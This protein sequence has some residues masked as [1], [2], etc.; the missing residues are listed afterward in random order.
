MARHLYWAYAV[1][2]VGTP[3]SC[4][5]EQPSMDDLSEIMFHHSSTSALLLAVLTVLAEKRHNSFA[6]LWLYRT[7]LMKLQT[8][9]ETLSSLAGLI[10]RDPIPQRLIIF[11]SLC[12]WQASFSVW[13]RWS[14]LSSFAQIGSLRCER[15][16]NCT[17]E[18]FLI[19]REKSTVRGPLE[20]RDRQV[21]T[22]PG[23]CRVG[24]ESARMHR[25][26]NNYLTMRQLQHWAC[27]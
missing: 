13:A 7:N 17:R 21:E 11:W 15:G 9:Q 4:V 2:A 18:T 6:F 20:T 23:E 5:G 24:M 22:E 19:T 8:Q 16:R 25:V 1:G 10:Q 14:G 26:G 12:K 3:I 27:T